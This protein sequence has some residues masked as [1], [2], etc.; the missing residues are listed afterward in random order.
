MDRTDVLLI[1]TLIIGML[2]CSV[3]II[4]D[5]GVEETPSNNNSVVFVPMY[6]FIHDLNLAGEIENQYYL[7]SD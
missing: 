2:V 6:M 5:G 3:G 7:E 1:V 4:C